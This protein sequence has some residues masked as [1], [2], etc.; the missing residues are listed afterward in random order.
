MKKFTSKE[1]TKERISI[2]SQKPEIDRK[3]LYF[4]EVIKGIEG[5]I[6]SIDSRIKKGYTK[7][8]YRFLGIPFSKKVIID[9]YEKSNLIIKKHNADIDLFEKKRYLEMWNERSKTYDEKFSILK[10]ECEINFD[11]VYELAAQ[12][13]D[14]NVRL[15]DAMKVYDKNQQDMRVKVEFYL[16]IKQEVENAAKHGKTFNA[17]KV[18][19]QPQPQPEEQ[20]A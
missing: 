18:S 5:L 9:E 20:K 11:R 3:I 10:S 6:S 14:V 7:E 19:N 16:Y 15:S 1:E 8:Y 13:C 4:N 12:L 17:P 2:L